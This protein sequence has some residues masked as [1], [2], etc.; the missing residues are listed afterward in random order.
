MLHF[1]INSNINRNIINN[2][3]VSKKDSSKTSFLNASCANYL[4]ESKQQLELNNKGW[5]IFK[6]VTNPYEYIHTSIDNVKIS[7][8]RPLSRAFYKMTEML[9]FFNLI[10]VN[11]KEPFFSFHIAEGP[12]G[13]IEAVNY[14][15]KKSV[16]PYIYHNDTYYGMTLVDKSDS[17]IP[18]WS[19]STHF[20][21]NT[22]P[23]KIEYGPSGD[24]DLYKV[25]NLDYIYYNHKQLY[26]LVTGDGGFDF[27]IDF[28]KQETLAMKLILSEIIYGLVLTKNGGNFVVKIFDLFTTCSYEIIYLLSC[29]FSEV[30][31]CKP[32]TSRYGNSEKYIVC[33]NKVVEINDVKYSILRDIFNNIMSFDDDFSKISILNIGIPTHIQYAIQEVNCVFSERQLENINDTLTLINN[34]K[35]NEII[36]ELNEKHIQLSIEWCK[37]HNIQYNELKKQNLFA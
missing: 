6:K 29:F 18:G 32:D 12:G 3:Y 23:V 1:E 27:S 19:K 13:F 35:R 34:N 22:I 7:K 28:N 4:M 36:E 15:R 5:D 31:I 20:I 37:T 24:G 17:K 33:K 9:Y 30:Y 26:E 25:E 16:N 14:Y 2:L 21:S 8:Y 10:D 11:S